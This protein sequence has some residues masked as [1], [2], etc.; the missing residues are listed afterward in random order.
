M[1]FV[2]LDCGF[3]KSTLWF[4]PDAR[5]VFLAALCLAVPVVYDEPL[6][7]YPLDSMEPTGF[8]VPPGW[9]GLVAAG[10]PALI[11]DALKT[12]EVGT[13]ALERLAAPEAAS[14][15][16]AFAGRRLV[17]VEG[18]FIVLNFDTYREKD[19]GAAERMRRW[20]ERK[21][22]VTPVTRDER[23]VTRHTVTVT[24]H[25]TQAEAEAEAEE[26]K[27]RV[28]SS[29]TGEVITK[30]TPASPAATR[31]DSF[32]SFWTSYPKQRRFEK[33]KAEKAWKSLKPA[34]RALA[35]AGVVRLAN[36][37]EDRIKFLV[38]PERWLKNHRWED[39]AEG[40]GN[41]HASENPKIHAF[42]EVDDSRE[43]AAARAACETCKR[44]AKERPS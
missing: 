29:P 16:S 41:G 37:E 13:A 15:S 7:T 5:D 30:E 31:G 42:H 9:Y 32:D 12:P 4:D 10:A 36:I 22:N 23:N 14:R 8:L 25:V 6:K 3:L 19:Y 34:E 39:P 24:R 43:G 1:P 40:S 26:K 21:K 27:R 33:A 38:Y 18:G 35:L 28:P 2:K 17:R 11:H 44:K 20:R